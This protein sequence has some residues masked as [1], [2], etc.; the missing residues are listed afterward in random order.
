MRGGGA[1]S[2]HWTGHKNTKQKMPI[3][4]IVFV[5]V[6]SCVTRSLMNYVRVP[7][8]V[9]MCLVL[10]RAGDIVYHQARLSCVRMCG[11]EKSSWWAAAN[12]YASE[13]DFLLSC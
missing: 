1:E 7:V 8:C 11:S 9:C 3:A 4:W 13:V 2:L 6:V 10:A 5:F 12:G